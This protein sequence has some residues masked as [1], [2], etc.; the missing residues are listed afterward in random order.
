PGINGPFSDNAENIA[1]L[2]DG[3]T[4][5]NVTSI[6]H[7][8]NSEFFRSNVLPSFANDC[9]LDNPIAPDDIEYD[10]M[11]TLLTAR[12]PVIPCETYH[13]KLIIADVGDSFFDSAILL[14]AG[15]FAAGLVDVSEPGATAESDGLAN[16]PLEGCSDG[17]LVF[18]RV[19]NDVSEDLT[20][21]F[22]ISPTGTAE[23]GVDYTMETDSFTIPAGQL[24]DTLIVDI[25]SDNIPEGT[26]SIILRLTGTCNCDENTTEFFI[27]D[28]A[29]L[30][31]TLPEPTDD[32]AGTS[33]DLIPT[34][35]GGE[36]AYMFDWSSGGQD[37]IEQ[38]VRLPGD[39]MII[40]TVTDAC[41][42]SEMDTVLLETPDIQASLSGAYSL[43]DGPTAMVP[44]V[45]SGGTNYTVT[46]RENGTNDITLT[47]SSDTIWLEY[48]SAIDIEILSV[49]ADGC[50]GVVQGSATVT[51][52]EFTISAIIQEVNCFG[53]DD[54]SIEVMVNGNSAGYTFDWDDPDAI[55]FNPTGLEAGTYTVRITDA[56]GCFSDTSFVINQP[57][58]AVSISPLA[59]ESQTCE[60]DASISVSISGG[61]SPYSIFWLDNASVSD[62]VRTGLEGD[63]EYTIVVTD[64]NGCVETA[65]F[66]PVDSR[67]EVL[68][69]ISSTGN[70]LTCTEPSVTL[71][72][73]M[74][75]QPVMH[76]WEDE[77][78]NEV[79]TTSSLMVTNG[80]EYR[81][82][83]TDPAT[84]C[85]SQDSFIVNES[86]D[87]L[88]IATGTDYRLTCDI[89]SLDLE[90]MAI[91]F[92]GTV[93]YE[94][95]DENG[96]SLGTGSNLPGITA[97]G[98]YTV[99]AFRPDNG[100]TA[101]AVASVT[102]DRDPPM[103]D[104]I[105]GGTLNCR[106]TTVILNVTI[107]DTLPYGYA[108]ATGNGQILGADNRESIEAA[109][110]GTYN[111]RVTNLSNGCFTDLNESVLE[112]RRVLTPIAGP[113]QVLPCGGAEFTLS[114]SS[115]PNLP[116]TGYRWL[117]ENDRILAETAEFTPPTRGTYTLE[118][119]H[120]ESFCSTT[121][122]VVVT[123]E[124]P[125]DFSF[126][127]Q[128]PP[129][130][131]IGASV[132][133][134][135]VE[136]GLAPYS[137]TI[138]GL[139]AELDEQGVIVGVP[140]GSHQLEVFDANGCG[141]AETLLIFTPAVFI[142]QADVLTTR[143]GEAV[144]LGV[145][146]NRDS[147]IEFI[148]WDAPFELSCINCPNPTIEPGA[149]F[150]ATATIIDI[151]GCTITV[152]QKWI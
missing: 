84:G 20:V 46:I 62:S 83:V 21:Y 131:E 1:I 55:G 75:S 16:A 145:Q 61:Q 74:N 12:S 79:G 54:G 126:S 118:V 39:S 106:D 40:L 13:L 18:N 121:D 104:L 150:T 25:F 133:I 139:P 8:S 59:I 35:N 122:V 117:D 32:C 135:E 6:N 93:E 85:F 136:G 63:I 149:S 144:T 22:N 125:V 47:G 78:G 99:N 114:G 137:Y 24:S 107:P 128:Q 96:V 92:G 120:P 100:C 45:L 130:V 129:C 67:E 3:L 95:F 60:V 43:C 37:S 49:S 57:S 77:E 7:Q 64:G 98:D 108:W 134:L 119:I 53:G 23:F 11:T 30:D 127:I 50:D 38:I 29:P 48:S 115:V 101:T 148:R 66:T 10:G 36:G 44:I 109:A 141:L 72:A 4:T 105:V 89:N 9:D 81:L 97:I 51:D 34:V 2:P 151:N 68:A 70:S 52:S 76:R 142:G 73:D 87:I 82:I 69:S 41:E 80:G 143:L 27:V 56:S 113:D 31:M 15:S 138:D 71:T 132:R 65:S 146:T 86:D 110:V 91:D 116:G 42:Q 28:P 58:E 19:D 147:L 5:I 33:V 94:W 140:E 90:V 123:Q 152:P 102:E 112:D 17:Q 88:R 14:R 124:G 103:V 26:E 111:V